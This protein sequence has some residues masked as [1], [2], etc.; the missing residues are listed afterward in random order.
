MGF[1]YHQLKIL[2]S[3]IWFLSIAY[4]LAH[5]IRYTLIISI[6]LWYVIQVYIIVLPCFILLFLFYCFVK[7]R[8]SNRNHGPWA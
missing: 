4:D 5:R 6:S 3:D 1:E 8:L 2:D 7:L